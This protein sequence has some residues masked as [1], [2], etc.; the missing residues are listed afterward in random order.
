MHMKKISLLAIALAAMI[1]MTGC[2]VVDEPGEPIEE[3]TITPYYFHLTHGHEYTYMVEDK[4]FSDKPYKLEMEME[5]E[6]NATYCGKPMYQCDWYSDAVQIPGG[7]YNGY[8]AKDDQSAYYMGANPAPTTAVWLDLV[9]P[10]K[11]GQKWSFPYGIDSSNTINAEITKVGQ[12][13]VLKDSTG[14][15]VTY[16]DVIE[17]V[18]QGPE[19]KTVKWFARD[20]AMLAE[21]RYDMKGNIIHK[22]TLWD[23]YYEG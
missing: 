1:N 15:N 6:Y 18:Y 8:Y 16:N 2:G 13:A 22:K 9:A 7:F 4:K 5:G 19:D 23:Y 12:V 20:H 3:Q 10:I 17:V 21:W 11:Q 14:K